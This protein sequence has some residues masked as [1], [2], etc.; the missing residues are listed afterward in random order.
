MAASSNC[1]PENAKFRILMLHGY[2]QT[3]QSLRI[4]TRPLLQELTQTLTPILQ[5]RYPGGIEYLFPDGPIDLDTNSTSFTT[6]STSH[7]T[8]AT[9]L[10]WWLNLDDTSRYIFLNDTV[11]YLSNFLD[12]KPIHA[13]IGFS[14]GAALAVMLAAMCEAAADPQRLQAIQT[15]NLPVDTFLQSLSGQQPLEFVLNFC[16]FRGTMEYYSILYTPALST[17]SFHAIGVF[18]TMITAEES[19]ELLEAFVAPEV[20]WFFGGH[21][22]PRDAESTRQV[23]GFVKRVCLERA[24][25]DTRRLGSVLTIGSGSDSELSVSSLSGERRRLKKVEV[26]VRKRSPVQMGWGRREF[27]VRLALAV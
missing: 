8:N 23:V 9:R 1:P 4:K 17:P 22:V 19:R 26:R 12:G 14:Q 16:G 18:D 3:A 10:A 27:G 25:G 11:H 7:P 24:V 2:A 6:T 13:I 21:F 15:Q 5:A 20:R